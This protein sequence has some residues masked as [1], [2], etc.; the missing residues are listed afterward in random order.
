MSSRFLELIAKPSYSLTVGHAI[1]FV[2]IKN[3][4]VMPSEWTEKEDKTTSSNNT[5]DAVKFQKEESPG[6][7]KWD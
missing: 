6:D 1:I 7:G 2:G 4:S 3:A 5:N